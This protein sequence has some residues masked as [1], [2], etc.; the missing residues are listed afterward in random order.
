MN[1]SSETRS[2]ITFY[3]LFALT[4]LLVF[5]L[6]R[7][8]LGVI[9]FS[10]VTVIALKPLYNRFWYLC[11]GWE[12]LA[13]TLTLLIGLALPLLV[14]WIVGRMV[15]AQAYQFVNNLQQTNT[16]EH[17]ADSF[18]PYLQPLFASD[19]PFT[20]ELLA[21]LRQAL[22]VVISWLAGALVNLG[23]SI[24]DLLVDLFVYL[25]LVGALLPT[26][27]RF[28]EWL[29]RLSPLDDAIE[30][31]FL[32]KISGTVQSM[33][34]GIF[35]VAVVQGLAMG[36]F[37][38]LARLPYTPLWTLVAIVAATLP[39]GASVVALPAAIAQFLGGNYGSGI[40]I[41]VGYFLVVSNLDLLIR[42]KLVSLQT[43]GSFALMLLSLLG[44]YQLFGLFGVFYGPILM[45]LF[46]TMLDVYQTRFASHNE[47]GP[48]EIG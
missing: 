11:K 16:I 48:G 29:K 4:G 40:V 41:L 44:G 30:D 37:F 18:T 36:V 31:L 39:L 13:M 38:W 47:D 21:Q 43:Y 5:W 1:N 28:V 3:L 26:Y 25:V 24:P 23:M 34:A 8:Y 45:V 20:L 10:F 9:A 17:L 35:L 6:V 15:V 7:A 12:K 14:V 33:F 19:A 46:L 27:D 32:R 42:S 22:I 2:Q